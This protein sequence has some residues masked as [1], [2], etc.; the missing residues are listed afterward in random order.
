VL[1]VAATHARS[2]IVT[3]FSF[4]PG[5][6]EEYGSAVASVEQ[7]ADRAEARIKRETAQLLRPDG[8]PR[9]TP[10]EHAE[11]EAAIREAATGE[12][13]SEVAWYLKKAQSLTDEYKGK[14]TMLGG[15]DPLDTLTEAQRQSAASRREFVREDV[16]RLAPTVLAARIRTALA[17]NDQVAAVL[18]A[19]YLPDRDGR[20]IPALTEAARELEAFLGIDQK[21]DQRRE[22][23]AKLR[24]AESMRAAVGGI[25]R[26][27]DG[28]NDRMM[29]AMRQQYARVL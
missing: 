20:T 24:R 11:R 12:F 28:S 22:L 3:D 23:M 15:S 21:G 13:D 19:R 17:G 8:S 6:T 27:V 18:Y 16:E 29:A 26:R 5:F 10:V 25:R 7:Y 9:Y 1:P 4:V 14:L 2:S